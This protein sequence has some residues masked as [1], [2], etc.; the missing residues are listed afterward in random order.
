[1]ISVC[2]AT[3][4]GEAY[5]AKQVDSILSQLSEEDEIVISD[6]HS[7]DR[8]LE[9]LRGYNDPRIRIFLNERDNR[10][11]QPVQKVTYNFENALRHAQGDY[12]FLSDQ[13]D[14]W[15]SNKVEVMMRYLQDYDYVQSKCFYTDKDLQGDNTSYDTTP[16]HINR[17]KSLISI[18]PYKG[19]C[20]AITRRLLDKA[21]PFPA[22]LQSHDRWLG[23]LG[24]FRYNYIIIPDKLVYYRRHQGNVSMYGK[25]NNP[26]SYRIKTR[27]HYVK[28]LI[29]RCL[30]NR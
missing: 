13:D 19:C 10:D 11:L 28:C 15:V 23:Y 21:L 30:F 12:I 1:M 27:L 24:S 3:Y 4:N 5:I 29:A 18:A 16:A 22:G 6:D 20:A 9:I 25:S 17:W 14:A 26:L 7:T 2:V 8:T